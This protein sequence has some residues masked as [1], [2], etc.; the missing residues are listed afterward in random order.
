MPEYFEDS[1]YSGLDCVAISAIHHALP[2]PRGGVGA[3]VTHT[4]HYRP[5]TQG[6]RGTLKSTIKPHFRSFKWHRR[7]AE[8]TKIASVWPRIIGETYGE[9]VHGE[10]RLTNALRACQYKRTLHHQRNIHKEAF[11]SY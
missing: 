2:L 3:P 5:H 10:N 7:N 1:T 8:T 6:C 4:R 11:Y 9:S